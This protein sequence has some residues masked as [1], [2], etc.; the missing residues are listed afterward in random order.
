M[1]PFFQKIIIDSVLRNK[2]QLSEKPNY[3][4]YAFAK[5]Y[6][7]FRISV[8]AFLRDILLISL[9]IFSAAFGLRGFLIPNHF[10][11]GGATGIALLISQLTVAKLEVMLVLIN[12]PFLLFGVGCY[13]KK[14]RYKGSTSDHRAC[15]CISFCGISSCYR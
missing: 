7:E 8:I 6:R 15:T 1:N 5:A 9:G 14:L 3:S 13:R 10:I 2:E 12:I 4:S 11:D